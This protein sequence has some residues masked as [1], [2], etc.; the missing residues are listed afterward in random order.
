MENLIRFI[1]L[2]FFVE[3]TEI[4]IEIYLQFQEMNKELPEMVSNI[5]GIIKKLEFWE[6]NL[7]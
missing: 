3:F 2:F 6:E 5:K 4:L 1:N 7:I